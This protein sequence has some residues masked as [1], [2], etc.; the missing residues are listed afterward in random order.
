MTSWAL[1][2]V[3]GVALL[4]A[5]NVLWP[6]RRFGGPSVVSFFAGWLAG[7]LALYAAGATLAAAGVLAA[8]GAYATDVGRSGSALALVAVALFVAGH[9][10][11]ARAHHAV[12]RALADLED[13]ARVTLP[14]RPVVSRRHVAFHTHGDV[15]LRL[16]VHSSREHAGPRPVLLYVHGGAW[17]IGH[18]ERQGLPLMK[19]MAARGWVCVSV[20]YRL[21]PRATF[22][23]HLVDVK[24][25]IVW[26]RDHA[27][28]LDADLSFLA[29]AGNSAGAHLASLAA[30]TANRPAY[31]PAFEDRDTSVDACVGFYGIYDFTDRFGHW[32]HPGMRHLLERHVMKARLADA[33]DAFAAASPVDQVHAG[34]PPFLLVHGTHDSL[35]P[36]DESRRLF[37]ALKATS[38]AP[39]FYVEVPGAQHAFEVF[40]STRTRH[41]VRGTARFLH[42]ALERARLRD[43][44]ANREDTPAR[45]SSPPAATRSARA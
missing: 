9:V 32:P 28:E 16:D 36:V 44:Q 24:R 4:L 23:D 22:P 17:M 41:V 8:L 29:I 27:G 19:H 6:V 21:S 25:A 14:P 38:R 43:L 33:R 5:A 31:Q 40:P 26:V 12:T 45:S 15:T 37:A 1:L 34:A 13:P 3:G 18:R 2:G 11:A 39:A 30:L 10:R 7:E 20:D 35:A 42:G